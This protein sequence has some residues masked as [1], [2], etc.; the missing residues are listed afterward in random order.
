MFSFFTEAVGFAA[1]LGTLKKCCEKDRTLCLCIYLFTQSV[2]HVEL[3]TG[4]Y[5]N[6]VL[7]LSV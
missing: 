2:M 6:I 4:N 1:V 7:M 5:W 3:H